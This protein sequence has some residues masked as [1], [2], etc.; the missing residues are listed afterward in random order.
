MNL[1]NDKERCTG[2]T[3][4]APCEHRQTCLRYLC[5]GT[6]GMWTPVHLRMCED[7]ENMIEA[8]KE[9]A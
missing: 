9:A 4:A 1:P 6:L 2:G 8:T 3:E 7:R 5:L